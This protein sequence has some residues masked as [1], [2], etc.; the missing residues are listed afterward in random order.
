MVMQFCEG[1]DL[2]QYLEIDGGFDEDKA[3]RYIAEILTAIEALHKQNILFRDLK[4][5]NICLDAN[6]LTRQPK[7]G[8]DRVRTFAPR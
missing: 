4:P 2:S 1:G 5:D 3:R 8:Q 7:V 6:V